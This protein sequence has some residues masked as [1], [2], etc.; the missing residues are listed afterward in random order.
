MPN[1]PSPWTQVDGLHRIF[2]G[3][4]TA[5]YVCNSRGQITYA[6]ESTAE[7][8]GCSIQL[9]DPASRLAKVYK[10]RD[11]AGNRI[12]YDQSCLA[13]AFL[14]RRA[15]HGEDIVIERPDGT[16]RN[17]LAF[18]TPLFEG[19]SF[20]GTV[21]ALMDVT[22][23]KQMELSLRQ[24]NEVLEQRVL[25][26]THELEAAKR[27][28]EIS[29]QTKSRF[30]AII[31]HDLRT[32][33]SGVLIATQT[34]LAK[35]DQIPLESRNHL[36]SHI[37]S[38]VKDQVTYVNDL[39]TLVSYERTGLSN[40]RAG[41]RLGE[42]VDSAI[43][44][45]ALQAAA[46]K[47][48]I[49]F[50]KPKT[51]PPVEGDRNQLAHLFMNLLSN[52]VKFTPAGGQIS[53]SITRHQGK[54]RVSVADTGI[55]FPGEKLTEF[56]QLLEVKQRPG[57][58]GEQGTGLGLDIVHQVAEVH[59]ATIEVDSKPGSGTCISISFPRQSLQATGL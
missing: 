37:S 20:E 43:K 42:I 36:L 58:A 59:K 25:E 14:N 26:R 47:V 22:R 30:L 50:T 8:W 41:L 16:F 44:A 51:E 21:S 11:A 29:E 7:T 5:I 48:A 40:F 9:N 45:V 57:T 4:P 1:S 33:L 32:P 6:N 52:S 15:C 49:H 10:L 53:V 17:L 56:R 19:E 13:Q 46:K 18:V 3:L 55:G 35:G 31:S 38:C 34:M 27:A 54:I 12:S 23:I 24:A 2:N 28:A 39:S